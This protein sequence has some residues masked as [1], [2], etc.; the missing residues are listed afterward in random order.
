MKSSNDGTW[1][2]F[3]W[4]S[5]CQNSMKLQNMFSPN[6]KKQN[7]TSP[8]VMTIEILFDYWMVNHILT[9]GVIDRP[10]GNKVVLIFWKILIL[11]YSL[12]L[13]FRWITFHF[14]SN[15]RIDSRQT[16]W[17]ASIGHLKSIHDCERRHICWTVRIYNHQYHHSNGANRLWLLWN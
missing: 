13:Q 1:I 10:T 6:P 3:Y 16:N 7:T 14:L 2:F 11:W 9:L 12:I 17:N 8:M 15:P 4:S 5:K